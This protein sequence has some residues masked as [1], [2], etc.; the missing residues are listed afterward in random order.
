[1]KPKRIIKQTFPVAGMHCAVCAAR[2][3]RTLAE[4]AGVAQ[5]QVNFAA[6]TAFVEYDPALCSP[7]SLRQAVQQAGYELLTDTGRQAE[8]EAEERRRQAYADLRRRTIAAAVL[9][10]PLFLISMF[11]AQTRTGAYL[12]WALS[13]PVVFGLG[14]PFFRGAG[15][16]LRRGTSNMD[17]LV[18]GSTG[19]AYLFSVFNL[20]FPDFWLGRGITPHLYFETA[21]GIIA[22][23]LLGRLLEERAKRHTSD[24]IRRLMGLQPRTVTVLQDGREQEQ[25]V[26]SVRPGHCIVAHPGERIAVDGRVE[27]GRS[28]VDESLLSGE[29]LP[30]KKESG[31]RVY[32]GTVN[33]KGVL[34]YRAEQTGRDTLL[35]QI[36]AR[37]QEA[38]G[39]KAPVQRAV[40]RVAAVFVPLIVGVAVLAFLAWN[41]WGGPDG[42]VRG[43][44]AFV[45]VLVIACPCALG[46][47]TPTALMVGIG[48]G[49]EH[50]ILVKDATSLETAR[51]VDVLVLDKTGTLTEGHPRVT[52]EHWEEEAEKHRRALGALE[53]LSEHPL[54]EA[55]VRHLGAAAGG[56]AGD[57]E[58]LPGRGICGTVEG[59]TYYAGNRRLLTEQGIAPTSAQ[60]QRAAGWEREAKTVIWLAGAGR[61]VA[62]LAVTDPLKPTAA[63]AVARL[64]GRGIEVHMLTGDNETAAR[65]VAQAAG[66]RQLK[67]GVLP[68]EKAAYV[69]ALQRAGHTVGMVGDG[70]NDSAALAQA[71]L[72][73][74]MGQGSDVAMQA[75]MI[76]ILTPDL[77]KVADTVCL[78]ALTV[79]TIRQNLFWAFVY[80]LVAVPLAAGALYPFTGFLLNPMVGGAAMALSSLS[81]VTNSLRLKR[82]RLATRRRGLGAAASQP[83]P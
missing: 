61:V 73:I 67:G 80:N 56:E 2:V 46:L 14:A 66:I 38:Q 75:A 65:A 51:R 29:P 79:R 3:N 31:S 70:I 62:Q 50:G 13:T 42:F 9:F 26:E 83:H 68:T 18:A 30:V 43:L 28:H 21:A 74:A 32:A 16:Q 64:Q 12:L 54:A 41:V 58:A 57:F 15:R 39:S 78:S 19:V 49:A 76:T 37:V 6:A 4:Q 63:E 82:K 5:A 47:A 20:L 10:V 53:R 24:A 27:S 72:S 69:E 33:G 52:D 1:M 81:V 59:T 36:I 77:R 45:T 23:I 55:V 60:Q 44:L 48:K 35:A 22:F 8:E 40:D 71:D 34:F 7:E 25:P 17:T 11:F